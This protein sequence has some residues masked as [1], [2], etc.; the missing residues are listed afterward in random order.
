MWNSA[1]ISSHGTVN[2]AE[3]TDQASKT[4]GEHNLSV[5]LN[6]QVYIFSSYDECVWATAET[7]SSNGIK[8]RKK[9]C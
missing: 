4:E 1:L 5:N 2:L 8:M 7:I 3:K 9:R 6:L